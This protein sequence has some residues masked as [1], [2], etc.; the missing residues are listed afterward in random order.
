MS[1]ADDKLFYD[2]VN[3]KVIIVTNKHFCVSTDKGVSYTNTV[4]NISASYT[5][6]VQLDADTGD[7]Y[8]FNSLGETR[9]YQPSQSGAGQ[10]IK[11]TGG[12]FN[13]TNTTPAAHHIKDD[14]FVVI[15]YQIVLLIIIFHIG[16][17]MAAPNWDVID[18]TTD[19]LGWYSSGT[20]NNGTILV[21]NYVK[22]EGNKVIIRK[23]TDSG[24]TFSI[25]ESAS[26]TLQEDNRNLDNHIYYYNGAWHLVAEKA[27]YRSTDGENFAKVSDYN[28]RNNYRLYAYNGFYI[29]IP[30]YNTGELYWSSNG[31]N[32]E[33]YSTTLTFTDANV[34]F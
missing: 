18:L 33:S 7:I 1:P 6:A 28:M 15:A 26:N 20:D 11:H 13:N 14:T 30:T 25:L 24:S 8:I 21:N 19:D 22:S 2:S 29:L 32:F 16:R 10:Q 31:I 27:I 9:W 4:I 23:S 12:P 17:P 5:G 3:D 34:L